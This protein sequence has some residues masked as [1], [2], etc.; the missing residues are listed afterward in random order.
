MIA[1]SIAGYMRDHGI[2]QKYVCQKTGLSKYIISCAFHGKRKLS[3]E[4]YKKICEALNLP[5]EYFLNGGTGDQ[6]S[7]TGQYKIHHHNKT[8]GKNK[9]V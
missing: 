4:E 1:E 6:T 2:K 7:Q 5:Y 9:K 8:G 3:V